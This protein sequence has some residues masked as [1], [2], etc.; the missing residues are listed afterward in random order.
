MT[1]TAIGDGSVDTFIPKS[2]SHHRQVLTPMLSGVG[3][4]SEPERGLG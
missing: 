2:T 4:C 1:D 3:T